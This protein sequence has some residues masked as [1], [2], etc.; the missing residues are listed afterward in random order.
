MIIRFTKRNLILMELVG[1]LLLHI[2]ELAIRF[3][4]NHANKLFFV[5]VIVFMRCC[6]LK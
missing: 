5:I 1:V 4:C 6:F 3:P 2:A